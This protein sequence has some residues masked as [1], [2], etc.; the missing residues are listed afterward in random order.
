MHLLVG[1]DIVYR[2]ENEYLLSDQNIFYTTI[3]FDDPDSITGSYLMLDTNRKKFIISG[4]AEVGLNKRQKEY[5]S[6]S[7]LNTPKDCHSNFYASYPHSNAN[8]DDI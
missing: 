2:K 6:Y 8:T 4:T 7:W 1:D 3:D 5:I